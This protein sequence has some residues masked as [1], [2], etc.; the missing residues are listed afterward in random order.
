MALLMKLPN[1]VYQE[2]GEWAWGGH[3]EQH[4]E[5]PLNAEVNLNHTAGVK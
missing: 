5:K 1:S 2:E 4:S 3:S